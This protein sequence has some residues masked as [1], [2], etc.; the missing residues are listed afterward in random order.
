MRVLALAL[1]MILIAAPVALAGP[2][3]DFAW[4]TP[5]PAVSAG[6]AARGYH[7]ERVPNRDHI[8]CEDHPG[9]CERHPETW[10]CN[11]DTEDSCDL[12]WR[13]PD[14]SVVLVSVSDRGGP[15]PVFNRLRAATRAEE[16]AMFKPRP[17]LPDFRSK[18]PYPVVRRALIRQGYR[19][20]PLDQADCASNREEVC[21]RFPENESCSGTGVGSCLFVFRRVSDGALAEVETADR[22]VPLGFHGFFLMDP[23]DARS[24]KLAQPRR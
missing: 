21:R 2:L 8:A 11:D 3:P 6:L 10:T 12:V 16:D 18:T 24:L 17:Q 1:A 5:Y 7:P 4:N 14:R 23:A 19:P 9:L 15:A 22:G 20:Q 13:A